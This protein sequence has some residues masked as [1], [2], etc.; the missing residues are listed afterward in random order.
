[1]STQIKQVNNAV[2]YL[3]LS[4]INISV[5]KDLNPSYTRANGIGIKMKMNKTM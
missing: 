1:M 5:L 2:F 4:F 3:I